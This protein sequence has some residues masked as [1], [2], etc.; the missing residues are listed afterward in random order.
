MNKAF[1]FLTIVSF[2]C[3]YGQSVVTPCKSQRSLIYYE[4]RVSFFRSLPNSEDEIIFLGNSLTDGAE[5][6]EF[7]E[8]PSVKNRGI[9]GD[10]IPG[11]IDRLDEVT[12]SGPLKIFLMIGANDLKCKPLDTILSEYQKLVSR[13]I[14]TTPKTKLYIQSILPVIDS[15]IRNNEDIRYLNKS[16]AEIANKHDV[17]FIDLYAEFVNVEGRLD[18]KYT[19]DGVHLSGTGYLKWKSMIED[20]VRK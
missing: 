8:N 16:L 19:Y 6:Q 14:H 20:F 2:F 4:G 18:S 10:D 17:V 15:E 7:F 13:I 9:S 3:S 5:W 1:F 11:V 12:E